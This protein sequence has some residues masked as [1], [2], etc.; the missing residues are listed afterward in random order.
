MRFT[1]VFVVVLATIVLAGAHGVYA[2][3]PKVT[4]SP[5]MKHDMSLEGR[6]AVMV[7]VQIPPGAEEGRHSHPAEL[8]V[9]V[10]E[11]ALTLESE[12]KETTTYNAGEVFN[13][14][15]GK[16]HNGM[17]KGDVAVKLLAVLI[18][19]KGKPISSPAK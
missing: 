15:P 5:L 13:V 16:V 17:N 9:Y 12:G 7:D 3:A 2:E 1:S 19:E 6:L 4:K 18:A 14:G 10:R 11:G 8:Y